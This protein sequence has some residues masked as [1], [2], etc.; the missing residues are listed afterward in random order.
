MCSSGSS[1]FEA[2][3]LCTKY[4]SNGDPPTKPL[5]FPRSLD[6]CKFFRNLGLKIVTTFRLVALV[7]FLA[8]VV[9]IRSSLRPNIR[10]D[11]GVAVSIPLPDAGRNTDRLEN[12]INFSNRLFLFPFC[13]GH[14]DAGPTHGWP[15]P[16]R[17]AILRSGVNKDAPREFRYPAHRAI[18]TTFF[19]V[20]TS[21]FP[22]CSCLRPGVGHCRK[23]KEKTRVV[24]RLL[25]ITIS[26]RLHSRQQPLY[27]AK[28][29][30]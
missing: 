8:F 5:L 7:R 3:A 4:F 27:Q 11:L 2:L 15:R 18:S 29:G 10:G 6:R 19:S 12:L 23:I 20:V 22:F 16:D 26:R 28:A 17:G 1:L 25:P 14:P 30:A 9:V 13:T 21:I 24:L